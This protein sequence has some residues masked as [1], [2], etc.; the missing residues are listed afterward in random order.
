M[1][2]LYIDD[3]EVNVP[4]NTTVLQACDTIGIEVPRF[5]FHERLLIAG[6]CRMC[7][8]EI[9]KSPKPVPSCAFPVMDNMRVYTNT[10]LVKK[11]QES[12]LEFLLINH[13][14]DC[15]ICDQGGECDLQD[16]AMTF[17]SDSSRFYSAKRGVEDKN[18]GPL[19][20]TIMT[21]CIHCTRCIRFATEIA[22]VPDLGTTG[23]GKKTEIGTYIKKLLTSEISGNIIDLCPVGALT[24]KPYAFTAR[25]WE[26]QNIETIDVMDSLGSNIVAS[27]KGNKVMRILPRINE[28]LNEEWITNKTRFSY[29]GFTVQRLTS[30]ML[31]DP[32]TGL[33]EKITWERSFEIIKA[34]L[35]KIPGDRIGGVIGQFVDIKTFFYFKNLLN[36]LGSNTIFLEDMVVKKNQNIFEETFN[37]N[38]T[39]SEIRNKDLCLIVDLNPRLELNAL[40][41][42]LRKKVINNEMLVAYIGPQTDFTFNVTHLGNDLNAFTQILKGNHPF[43]KRLIQAKNPVIINPTNVNYNAITFYKILNNNLRILDYKPDFVEKKIN[44]P[45]ILNMG[46]ASTKKQYADLKFF[47]LLGSAQFKLENAPKDSFVIYC[48]THGDDNISQANLLLPSAIFTEKSGSFL[49]FEK[50]LQSTNKIHNGPGNS[51]A[52][53]QIFKGLAIFLGTS[54]QKE[55]SS[56]LRANQNFKDKLLSGNA[57][58]IN[59][60][61]KTMKTKIVGKKFMNNDTSYYHDNVI[62]KA[63]SIL[64]E[65]SKIMP[66]LNFK[67]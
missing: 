49:N 67:K 40:N 57:S 33:F 6:N 53:W 48:G 18:T 54:I 31:K 44:I 9:E 47:F 35:K 58:F 30:P 2:K 63:S 1:V 15:P 7:L 8:V 43:C 5:C 11:A 4:S 61:I 32:V 24:S 14:L 19:I 21:R 13:P 38:T 62:V 50:R 37:F 16:Q 55:D 25:S 65:C 56:L 45:G 66:R 29:D 3:I 42:H 22:G 36:N 51:R 27:V 28:E 23:R 52:D 39:V 34:H 12:V 60:E 26:L 10:P 46:I 20:K 59:N 41:L 17:G 64:K